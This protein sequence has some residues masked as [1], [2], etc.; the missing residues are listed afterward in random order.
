MNTPRRSLVKWF[1]RL[2]HNVMDVAITSRIDFGYNCV[3]WALDRTDRWWQPGSGHPFR[4]WPNPNADSK[5]DSYLHMFADYG[6]SVCVDANL[7][8]NFSKIVIYVDSQGGFL[9]V[10]KQLDSG[11]WSS[12]CGGES[13]ITHR[14]PYVLEGPEY[15]KIWGYMRRPR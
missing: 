5:L 12:K 10:A 8:E 6:Y 7:E 14:T 15:G 2:R 1:P 3:A 4:Y 9:H 11:A 13:D